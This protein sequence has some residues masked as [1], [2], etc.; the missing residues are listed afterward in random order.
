MSLKKLTVLPRITLVTICKALVRP[1][2]DYGDILYD[3]TFSNYFYDKLESI[4]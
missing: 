2:L 1:H 3:Q 4:Q